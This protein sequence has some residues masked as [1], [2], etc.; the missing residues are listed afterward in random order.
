MHT[1]DRQRESREYVELRMQYGDFDE[2]E[3]AMSRAELQ[4]YLYSKAEQLTDD[5]LIRAVTS[6]SLG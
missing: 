1:K 3:E 4:S 2:R 5:Q 6:Y